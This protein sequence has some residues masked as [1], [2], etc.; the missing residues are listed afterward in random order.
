ML[1]ERVDFSPIAKAFIKASAEYPASVT[2]Q[3]MYLL[4]AARRDGFDV[5][6]EIELLLGNQRELEG[7]V[8]IAESA[9][10]RAS[11]SPS[12]NVSLDRVKSVLV[13]EFKAIRYLEELSDNE[14]D[15][16]FNFLLLLT[17]KENLN[18]VLRIAALEQRYQY[19]KRLI[20]RIR[21]MVRRIITRQNKNQE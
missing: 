16:F 18:E 4:Q 12:P 21:K 19:E 17:G 2:Y 1:Q 5:K 3:A 8:R 10:H 9:H 14:L 11:V 6:N 15:S 20:N 13:T 7:I